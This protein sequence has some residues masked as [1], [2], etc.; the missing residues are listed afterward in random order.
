[1]NVATTDIHI[2]RKTRFFDQMKGGHGYAVSFW[3]GYSPVSAP[4]L[5]FSLGLG[6]ESIQSAI[7]TSAQ[8]MVGI[9]GGLTGSTRYQSKMESSLA[10]I[11]LS[12]TLYIDA[13]LAASPISANGSASTIR[14]ATSS[15]IL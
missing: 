11:T 9:N 13:L 10:W 7:G 6:Y 15:P 12:A 1:L 8:G 5:A 4:A 14:T 3:T 2:L